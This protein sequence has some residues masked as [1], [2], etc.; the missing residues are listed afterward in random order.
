M[1]IQPTYHGLAARNALTTL[2]VLALNN[3]WGCR[4]DHSQLTRGGRHRRSCSQAGAPK[5]R[6]VSDVRLL[7]KDCLPNR[8]A[9]KPGR[10]LLEAG[11]HAGLTKINWTDKSTGLIIRLVR[12]VAL[13]AHDLLPIAQQPALADRYQTILFHL[14]APSAEASA[15]RA[16]KPTLN[17]ALPSSASASANIQISAP[18]KSQPTE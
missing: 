9:R 18:R 2:I 13:T 3:L 12:A 5:A 17:R 15:T 10:R 6:L 11:K 4:P 7:D 1:L 16:R 14:P 8:T